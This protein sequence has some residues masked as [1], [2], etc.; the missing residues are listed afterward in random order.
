MLERLVIPPNT[1]FEERGVVVEGDA[2]IGANSEI[3]YGISARKV[4]VGE[5]AKING[6]IFGREEVRLGAWCSV[7]GDVISKGDAY[8]GEFA[9][10]GGRLT[11]Y[12]NLEIGRNVRIK[13]GFE[14]RGLIR[15]QDPMPIIIFIFLYVLEL[16]RLGR[17]EEVEKLIEL[18]EF[19]SPLEVPEGSKMS[20]D[21]IETERD[22]EI[23]GSR[24]LGNVKARNVRIEKS[25][26]YGGV[27]G[28]QIV[29]DSSRVHGTVEGRDV[30]I[31]N[32]SVVLGQ[33]RAERVYMEEKCA[34]EGSII[35]RGGVWIKP[36]IELE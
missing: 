31:L 29:I 2:L 1:R 18:E 34:V 8:I 35:G 28:D 30:Y 21:V 25:E 4:I 12:G 3:G 22:V 17:A 10:I 6:D 7:K 13:N 33:I 24:V 27:R 14:A 5:R 9:S 23:V 32:E 20:L 16:L 36:M 15:I 19:L 11:V 26:L